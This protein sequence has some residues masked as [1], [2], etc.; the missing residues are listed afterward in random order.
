MKK[1]V[2]YFYTFLLLFICTASSVTLCATKK[3]FKKFVAWGKKSPNHTHYYIHYAYCKAFRHLG[4]E[5]LWLDKNDDVSTID[6]SNSLFL[7]EGQ[8]DKGMPLR[9]DCRYILHNCDSGKYQKLFEQGNCIK[10]Q[11]YTHDCTT[12]NVQKVDDLTYINIDK[13]SIYMPWATDLLPHEIEENKG[14]IAQTQKKMASYYVGSVGSGMFGNRDKVAPF[15]RACHEG[16]VSFS[17][18]KKVTPEEN[19]RLIQE[20]IVAPATQSE[21]QVRQGYIP[22]RIFKNISYGA[23]GVTNSE[24]VQDLFK[25]RLVYNPDTYQLFHDAYKRVTT[26]RMEELYEL[27]DMVKEKH[28]YLNRIEHLLDFMHLIKPLDNYQ[29]INTY[30]G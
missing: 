9:S 25:G 7:T 29:P 26:M 19:I 21:W 1:L 30:Q 13:K 15:S 4:Y 27:M 2:L 22:C 8:A 24:T 23:M 18:R 17:I 5:V 14:K 10:L 16:G 20:A 28:T 3:P 12:R 6:F 11:V